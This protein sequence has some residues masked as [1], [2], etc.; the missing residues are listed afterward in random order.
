MRRVLHLAW[1]LFKNTRSPISFGRSV[2]FRRILWVLLFVL[3]ISPLMVQMFSLSCRLFQSLSSMGRIDLGIS[4]GL[5]AFGQMVFVF[6]ILYVFTVYFYSDDLEYL[7][8]LPFRPGE[9]LAGKFLATLFYEYVTAFILLAPLL[10]ALAFFIPPNFLYFGYALVVFFFA[11]VIPL[12][13]ASI[14][15]FLSLRV[16]PFS[17]KKAQWGKWIGILSILLIVALNLFFQA[18][19]AKERMGEL[20]Q[21]VTSTHHSWWVIGIRWTF[22][23]ILAS[24]ALSHVRSFQGFISLL[25]FCGMSFLIFGAFLLIGNRLYFQFLSV[26]ETISPKMKASAL[27][28]FKQLAIWKTYWLKE[29]RILFREPGF[30]IHCIVMGFIWP[31]FFLPVFF[32]QKPWNG[33]FFLSEISKIS[34]TGFF[35]F[36]PLVLGMLM[37]ASNAIAA[38][39]LSR[40]GKQILVMRYVPV[41]FSMQL[42]AKGASALAISMV[43]ALFWFFLFVLPVAPSFVKILASLLLLFLGAGFSVLSGMVLDLLFP[44]LG[45]ED[46]S[47]LVRQNFNISLHLMANIV[48]AIFLGIGIAMLGLSGSCFW[49][50]FLLFLIFDFS[51]FWFLIKRGGRIFSQMDL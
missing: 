45:Q 17:K 36:V 8:S 9:I 20:S 38:T 1:I 25:G 40:E 28:R 19:S 16:L 34:N 14:F 26:S 33:G 35:Y 3:A 13:Y 4:F 37:A 5:S 7:L 27:F 42:L 21:V 39:F 49:I 18:V 24:H 48:L 10:F 46:P 15:V 32:F 22:G 47:R 44:K 50:L 23:S 6:G 31:I 43:G 41:S 11:P 12:S 51:L 29:I 2:H 30:F